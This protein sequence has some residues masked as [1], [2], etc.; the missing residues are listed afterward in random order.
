MHSNHQSEF[1]VAMVGPSRVGKTTLI[2]A[3]LEAGRDCFAGHDIKLEVP[4]NSPTE[5]R[6]SR[7]LRELNQH[8][9]ARRF[10]P[11]GIV[12]TSDLFVYELE[13]DPSVPGFMV[14]IN[15]VDFPGGWLDP[16]RRPRDADWQ[17]VVKHIIRSSVLAIP[18][19]ATI[20]MEVKTSDHRGAWE[21]LLLLPDIKAVVRSW[22]KERRRFAE[23]EPQKIVDM[24]ITNTLSI[25]KKNVTAG[26][27]RELQEQLEDKRGNIVKELTQIIKTPPLLVLAP[28]KCESYF[29]YHYGEKM[30]PSYHGS[31]R[32]ERLLKQVEDAYGEVMDVAQK[33][34]EDVEVLYCAVDSIGCVQVEWTNWESTPDK[35]WHLHCRFRV[36]PPYKR[37]L[38]EA[39]VLMRVIGYTFLK[40]AGAVKS[41]GDVYEKHVRNIIAGLRPSGFLAAIWEMLVGDLNGVRRIA[42]QLDKLSADERNRLDAFHKHLKSLGMKLNELDGSSLRCRFLRRNRR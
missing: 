14:K 10:A 27:Y 11:G 34:C 16:T 17:T 13:L 9:R 32:S 25:A 33:E 21:D 8:I 5:A 36:R 6:I 37:R 40:H 31:D 42:E 12:G 23:E 19:D 38:A 39:D 18:I 7:N 41:A 2:S 4:I 30:H 15:I 1:T 3:L 24:L 29:P 22:A 35:K 28:L 26:K 20:L